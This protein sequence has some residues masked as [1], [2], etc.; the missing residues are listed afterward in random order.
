MCWNIKL[1]L[2]CNNYI[3][4]ACFLHESFHI[5]RFILYTVCICDRPLSANWYL[6]QALDIMTV[7]ICNWSRGSKYQL[8][9]TLLRDL[10]FNNSSYFKNNWSY[11]FYVK[12]AKSLLDWINGVKKPHISLCDALK[13][14][15]LNTND[16]M[17]IIIL[18]IK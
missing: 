10:V 6:G 4:Q 13:G 5:G 16:I 7:N 9:H 2:E 1:H 12:S 8:I 14:H 3:S 18:V 11:G 17:M 15:S